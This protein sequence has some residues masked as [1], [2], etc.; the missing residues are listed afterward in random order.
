MLV[1]AGFFRFLSARS[2]FRGIGGSALVRPWDKCFAVEAVK[3]SDQEYVEQKKKDEPASVESV[4]NDKL[5]LWIAEADDLPLKASRL[6]LV[7]IACRISNKN[8]MNDPTTL[9]RGTHLNTLTVCNDLISRKPGRPMQIATMRIHI[10]S[11]IP[12][13]S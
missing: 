10:L 1:G 5:R 12:K 11:V 4:C 13:T 7:L 8:T 6:M 2:G 9:A 3:Y